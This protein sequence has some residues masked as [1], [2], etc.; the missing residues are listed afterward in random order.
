MHQVIK[1]F[2]SIATSF[3]LLVSIQS[4]QASTLTQDVVQRV[5]ITEGGAVYIRPSG[6][7]RWQ[8][9]DCDPTYAY[10]V[11]GVAGY[12]EILTLVMASKLNGTDIRFNGTCSSNG[13]YLLIDYAFL[14]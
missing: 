4:A 5:Q 2:F 13:N 6:L 3:L 8:G 1:V 12:N 14:Y 10:I 11:K 9:D 7:G